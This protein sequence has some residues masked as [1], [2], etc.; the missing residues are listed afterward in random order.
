[1][2]NRTAYK[3]RLLGSL[4]ITSYTVSKVILKQYKQSLRIERKPGSGRKKRF[5]N[6]NKASKIIR[7][8]LKHP[9]MSG[10]RVTQKNGFY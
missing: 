4:V 10:G 1:M 5:A 9:N 7:I 2:R 3:K 8:L 6:Q